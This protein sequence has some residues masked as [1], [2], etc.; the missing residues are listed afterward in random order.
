MT[1]F[2]PALELCETWEM[3]LPHLALPWRSSEEASSCPE[4]KSSFNLTAM[5]LSP[6]SH[7]VQQA[8]VLRETTIANLSLD[9]E[10]L[11]FFDGQGFG[12]QT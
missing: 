9:S 10:S 7:K 4:V 5:P 3:P 11:L 12:Q 6:K 8:L 1:R 2:P